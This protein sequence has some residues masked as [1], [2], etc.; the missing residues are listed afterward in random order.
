MNRHFALLFFL[1]FS[2]SS[3][4]EK[5]HSLSLSLSLSL[6]HFPTFFADRPLQPRGRPRAFETPGTPEALGAGE[7]GGVS[8]LSFLPPKRGLSFHS[9]L[10]LTLST[11]PFFSRPPRPFLSLSPPS[12]ITKKKKKNRRWTAWSA[13]S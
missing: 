2:T 12:T 3:S 5:N 6:L 1:S 7:G 4:L 13:P 11:F 9:S 8:V 10:S